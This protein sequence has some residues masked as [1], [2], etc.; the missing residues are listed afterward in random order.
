MALVKLDLKPDVEKLRSFSEI[1]LSASIV[2]SLLGSWVYSWSN[3][4]VYTLLISGLLVFWL[5]KISVKLI[6]PLYQLLLLLSF[7][8]GWLISHI[9]FAF[10]YYLIIFP[11]AIIFK[12]VGRDKLQLKADKES[13]W[14]DCPK[15]TSTKRYFQQF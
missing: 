2:F 15:A 7:P 1:A 6:L 13:Y 14:I 11:I 3:T 9:I 12:L 10:F 5:G 8:I 4:T